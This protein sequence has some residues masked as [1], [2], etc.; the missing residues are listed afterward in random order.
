MGRRARQRPAL[1]L[2]PEADAVAAA[3][4]KRDWY[5]PLPLW[6]LFLLLV[7]T[8][9]LYSA[10]YVYRT[11]REL[12]DH[13]NPLLTPALYPFS[14]LFAPVAGVAAARLATAAGQAA[15]ADQKIAAASPAL[16]GLG[17]FV[18][19]VG[20]ALSNLSTL[21]SVSIIAVAVY[22]LPWLLLQHQINRIKRVRL[23]ASPD[24]IRFRT[25]PE[26]YTKWQWVGLGCGVLMFVLV[27]FA[28]RDDYIRLTGEALPVREAWVDPLGRFMFEVPRDGWKIVSSGY[29]SDDAEIELAGPGAGDWALVFVHEQTGWTIDDLVEFR[30]DQLVDSESEYRETRRLIE[31]TGVAV[32]HADYSGFEL[33]DGITDYAVTSFVT[34]T[35]AVEMIVRTAG[36]GRGLARGRELATSL[37]PVADAGSPQ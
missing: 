24:A 22:A 27:G 5:P 2:L 8:F 4:D 37:S 35:R 36:A 31:G 29:Y 1:Q 11:A 6:K 12:R 34:E 9:G 14:L 33:L 13:S 28:L 30:Y 7:L 10:F 32:S 19:H 26:R 25:R 3:T 15:G 17:V 20:L 16:V 23:V 21:T 18:G